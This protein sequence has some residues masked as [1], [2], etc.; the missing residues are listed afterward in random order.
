M[1]NRTSERLSNRIYE[2]VNT[3]IISGDIRNP[4]LDSFVNISDVKLSKDN[5]YATLFVTSLNEKNL[6]KSVEALNEASA[7][8]QSRLA[9]ILSTKNT[10]KLRFVCD[11]TE[12]KAQKIEELINSIS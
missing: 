4:K 3:L 1:I 12:L 11:D 9:K 7:Y 10:P 8:I 2:A 6:N 5:A